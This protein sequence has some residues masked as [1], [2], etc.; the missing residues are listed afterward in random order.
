MEI[1]ET[2]AKYDENFSNHL[3]RHTSY[4]SPKVQNEI[5][6]I[7]AQLTLQEIVKEVRACGFFSLMVDE[8][9]VTKKNNYQ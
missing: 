5:I 4:C 6:D 1:C 2:F 9:S 3:G 7:V 8:A